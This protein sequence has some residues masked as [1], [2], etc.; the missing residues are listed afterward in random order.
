MDAGIYF[1]RKL[2]KMEEELDSLKLDFLRSFP[3]EKKKTASLKGLVQNVKFCEKDFKE[4]KKS[5][6]KDTLL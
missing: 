5:L 1:F 4:A 2:D 6:F 3:G